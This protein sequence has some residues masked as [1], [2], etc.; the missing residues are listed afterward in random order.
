[1]LGF[2][3]SV[4]PS[5]LPAL[6][7]AVRELVARKDPELVV[8]DFGHWGDGGIHAN[9]VVPTG[10]GLPERAAAELRADIYAVVTD[11]FGGSW[12][13]EHG[14]GPLNAA[15]W[16]ATT[17]AAERALLAA[18]KESVDPMRILGHPDLPFG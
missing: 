15:E 7:A 11:G 18:L 14:V 1:V 12:S 13:A 10:H 3:L 6:R 5:D 2:D 4:R 8:A 9:V 17:P 16:T